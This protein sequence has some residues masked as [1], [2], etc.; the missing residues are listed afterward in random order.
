VVGRV[1][2]EARQLEQAGQRRQQEETARAIDAL[3][4]A[5]AEKAER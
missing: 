3:P 2:R 4:V 5:W 1:N